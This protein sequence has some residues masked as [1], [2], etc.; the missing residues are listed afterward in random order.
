MIN[1]IRQ[2]LALTD[3]TSPLL[4]GLSFGRDIVLLSSLV[5][6]NVNFIHGFSE[7]PGDTYNEML[8]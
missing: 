2:R 5:N 6:V 4:T 8:F 7:K 3:I 1:A